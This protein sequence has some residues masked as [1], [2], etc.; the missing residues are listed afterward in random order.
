MSP[1][2]IADLPLILTASESARV[3][4]VST[5]HVHELVRRGVLRSLPDV[6]RRTLIP[7]SA[8]E[9]FIERAAS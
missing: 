2:T 3:L 7:R 6:G 1:T 9:N 5:A 4:R 8:I